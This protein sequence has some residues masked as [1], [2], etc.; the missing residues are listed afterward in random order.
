MKKYF[1]VFRKAN[2]VGGTTIYFYEIN[3]VYFDVF[4]EIESWTPLILPFSD[5][6]ENLKTQW[7]EIMS[8]FDK[9]PVDEERLKA[10]IERKAKKLDANS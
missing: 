4:G 9:S 6:V 2:R 8:A 1:R 10:D 3:Q 7:K 5:D